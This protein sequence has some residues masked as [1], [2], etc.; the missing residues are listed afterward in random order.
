MI[1]RG[2]ACAA[3]V[4][5]GLRELEVAGGFRLTGDG[6]EAM[7]ARHIARCESAARASDD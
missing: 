2:I 7:T 6:Q 4:D 5:D 3:A 1:G